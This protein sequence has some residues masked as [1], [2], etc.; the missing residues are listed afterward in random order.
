MLWSYQNYRQ[1]P[2][3]I[4]TSSSTGEDTEKVEVRQRELGLKQTFIRN[5]GIWNKREA[6]KVSLNCRLQLPSSAWESSSESRF[7]RDAPPAHLQSR[8]VVE[9]KL[10]RLRTRRRAPAPLR[11]ERFPPW[12]SSLSSKQL[13]TSPAHLRGPGQTRNWLGLD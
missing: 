9:Q 1:N 11:L 8:P 3:D 4:F 10:A 7:K 6:Y 2:S 5:A 12:A 13:Q